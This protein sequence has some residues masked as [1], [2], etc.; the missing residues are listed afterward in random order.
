M[1]SSETA[2]HGEGSLASPAIIDSL[3]FL[4]DP[5]AFT[6]EQLAGVLAAPTERAL[7]S[8][9]RSGLTAGNVTVA[10]TDDFELTLD[11]I[12][13][14]DGAIA[15]SGGRLHK[16][17]SAD[18]LDAAG[19]GGV[20]VIYGLQNAAMIGHDLSRIDVLKQG[21]V[22][23][24]QLTYN[25]Q[26]KLGSGSLAPHDS[27]LS[28]FGRD[29]VASLHEHNLIVDLSHGSYRLTMDVIAC[30]TNDQPPCIS[31]TG[32]AALA[33][34]PRNKTD[35]ELRAIAD[36]GGY[37]G[38]YVMPYLALGRTFTYDDVFAH[39]DHAINVCGEDAIGIGTDHGVCDVEDRDEAERMYG[40]AVRFRQSLGIS[41]PGEEPGLP[42]YPEGFSGI[43]KYRDLEAALKRN[44]YGST[45]IEKVLGANFARY[46]SA[47]WG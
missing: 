34:I 40:D 7:D 11:N 4:D 32:C 46:A 14:L 5:F 6:T 10:L 21:G 39:I 44:G 43:E 16:V 1:S 24:V 33:D 36:L 20:G 35:E 17:L 15:A 19:D 8:V 47:V 23:I 45:R 31:H 29:A 37:V 13:R 22:R 2:V 26:N 12:A 41:A 28:D 25:G 3:A 30:S 18:D 38:V 9:I 27:G 42:P